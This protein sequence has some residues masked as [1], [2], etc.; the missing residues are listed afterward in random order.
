MIYNTLIALSFA[1]TA[2][3][4]LFSENNDFQMEMWKNFKRDHNKSYAIEVGRPDLAYGSWDGVTVCPY[5]EL[6]ITYPL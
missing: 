2:S 5:V 4:A 6:S 1:A 3:A